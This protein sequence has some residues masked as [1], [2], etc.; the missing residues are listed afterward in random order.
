MVREDIVEGIK[1]AISRGETL[2]AAMM[3]F[4]T[5]G[6]GKQE[7][8][9]AARAVMMQQQPAMPQLQPAAKPMPQIQKQTPPQIQS[10]PM[11]AIQPSQIKPQPMYKPQVQQPLPGLPSKAV[12]PSTEQKVSKY[13]KQ[14]PKSIFESTMGLVILFILLFIFI[15]ALASVIIFRE[16][17]L[18]FIDSFLP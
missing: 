17:V 12:V 6:Y 3:S 18:T 9:D 5:A 11:P 1:S 8:E 10:R 4:Y 16:Q 13:E 7:I 15:G 14:P 2:Q